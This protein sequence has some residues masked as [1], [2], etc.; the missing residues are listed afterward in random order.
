MA[1]GS[2]EICEIVDVKFSGSTDSK[3]EMKI[4][5]ILNI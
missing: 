4:K 5:A 2:V 3:K 1:S